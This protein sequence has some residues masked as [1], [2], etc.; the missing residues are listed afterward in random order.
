M[1]WKTYNI[2]NIDNKYID[3]LDSHC[4]SGIWHYPEWLNFQLSSGRV[5]KGFIFTI[6]ED[7][8]IILAGIFLVQRSSYGINF[9]YIPAGFLYNSISKKIYD[10]FILNIFKVAKE[11]N[12]VF[13]QLDSITEYDQNFI[14]I[15]SCYKNH[16][17]NQ[18]L[19]IP[20][21]TNILDLNLTLDELLMQMKP[22]GRYNIKLAEKK[23]VIIRKGNIEEL[24]IFY[25]LLKETTER[26]NFRPN[27]FNYYKA[28]LENLPNSILL[29]A[30]HEKDILSS[31]IFTYT[32][33]QAL[34]YY[35]AS[36]NIKRNLMSSYL[37]QWEA[38]NIG[39]E[40]GCK[41]YDF[42]G[43]ADPSNP[44][45]QLINVTDFKLKFGGKIVRF[46]PSYHIIHQNITYN[47]YKI[48]RNIARHFLR[49]R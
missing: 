21:Y 32:K 6:E 12:L 29:F 23:G 25:S 38:I 44:K 37:L 47:F 48:S 13:T 3:F 45:D 18:K 30:E 15:I 11:F 24:S 36:S 27:P 31:G 49:K 10:F 9:G 1:E 33:N 8:T 26:D 34:Y 14:D 28:M 46:N 22:K 19:P 35:G 5:K 2:N 40:K 7:N 43:I 4:Y 42:M 20:S 41:Y 16:K 17:I 39:K